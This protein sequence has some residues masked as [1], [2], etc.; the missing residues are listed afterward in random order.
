MRR[1]RR[2]RGTG[3]RAARG[4][5]GL[6][7]F[8][9]HDGLVY[10]D[11]IDLGRWRRDGERLRRVLCAR[12]GPAPTRG[13]L[14]P[15]DLDGCLVELV[16]PQ[17]NHREDGADGRNEAGHQPDAVDRVRRLHYVRHVAE[18]RQQPAG[19]RA[20]DCEAELLC[21]GGRREHEPRGAPA[22]LPFG[23]VGGI[24]VHRPD[25]RRGRRRDQADQPVTGPN[26]RDI[27]RWHEVIRHRQ[28]RRERHGHHVE[29]ALAE[30]FCQ[31]RGQHHADDEADGAGAHHGAEIRLAV[32]NDVVEVIDHHRAADV[33]VGERRD[34]DRAQHHPRAVTEQV[35]QV[36]FERGVLTR[37]RLHALTRHQKGRQVQHH[38]DRRVDHHR[39][40]PA[41]RRVLVAAEVLGQRLGRVDDQE[42]RQER[43]HETVRA[44]AGAIL[45]IRRQHPEQRRVRDIDGRIRHHHEGQRDVRVDDPRRAAERRRREGQ[46][47]RYCHRHAH[48]QQVRAE[49]A[50]AAVGAVRDRADHRVDERIRNARDEHHRAHRR[51][52]EQ[53]HVGIK[54]GYEYR[55]HLPEE[56][57]G[58]VA[59]PVA[60]L[61]L[62]G[63]LADI[64]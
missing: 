55:E 24:G 42:Y 22:P 2:R 20:A 57:R 13:K 28:Q 43:H 50:P 46:H 47:R 61:L 62:D 21:E 19:A 3:T 23:I 15:H 48:P 54:L 26:Q 64:S 5:G 40:L 60:D 16:E 30:P 39:H 33:G 29:I 8:L 6:L 14:R 10:G 56:V 52:A 25:Q 53:E 32:G 35:A 36:V 38:R 59:E 63:E 27:A 12:R 58:K 17:R 45:G 41:D 44:G 34:A 4:R 37:L 18:V 11:R 49:V 7:L 31:R 1:G 51:G 9:G